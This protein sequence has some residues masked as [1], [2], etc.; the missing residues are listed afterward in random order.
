MI[1]FIILGVG[2]I[3]V[4]LFAGIAILGEGIK[5]LTRKL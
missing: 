5:W 2:L 4:F 1:I 3:G